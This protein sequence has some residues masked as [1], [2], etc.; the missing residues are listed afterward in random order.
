[1]ALWTALIGTVEISSCFLGFYRGLCFWIT[2]KVHSDSVLWSLGQGVFLEF[3]ASGLGLRGL[4]FGVLDVG[5]RR[6][7]LQY[8]EYSRVFLSAEQH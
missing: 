2:E 3:T 6:V 5:F 7:L 8:E 4:G 1:M